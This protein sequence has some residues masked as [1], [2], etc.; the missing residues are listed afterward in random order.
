MKERLELPML[1]RRVASTVGMTCWLPPAEPSNPKMLLL[2]YCLHL[3]RN[4]DLLTSP[5]QS[6]FPHLCKTSKW[7]AI[8]HLPIVK[9]LITLGV[10]S[11]PSGSIM[12]VFQQMRGK[13]KVWTSSA[14]ASRLPP[15]RSTLQYNR[16][17]GGRL[18][19]DFAQSLPPM[20]T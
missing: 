3:G 11:Y 2:S 18:N 17:L 7:H 4:L 14:V 12:A 10:A 19:T 13:A 6:N 1:H 9:E 15:D 20:R 16:N 5:Q 8:V